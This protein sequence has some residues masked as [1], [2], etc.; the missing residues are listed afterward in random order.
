[1]FSNMNTI[2]ESTN[3]QTHGLSFVTPVHDTYPF[4]SG[5]DVRALHGKSVLITGASKGIGLT[6]A[7]NTVK[8][9]CSAIV[10]AARSSLE[11][12][13]QAV[14][15]AATKAG[16]ENVRIV[17]IQLDVTS[18]ESVQRAAEIAGAALGGKLDVL[19]NNAGHLSEFQSIGD[20]DPEE[21]WKTWQTNING[22]YL[23]T[24]YFLPMLLESDTKT[25]INITS[26]GSQV[27]VPG[28]SAYQASKFAVCRFTEFIVAEYAAKGLIA[29]AL[30]PGG[31]PTE[32]A[33]GMPDW[34]H[35]RLVDTAELPADTM[36]WLCRERREWL[37]GRFVSANWH[38]G[39]LERR[40]EEIVEKDLLKF[41]MT[42]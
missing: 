42:F 7:I 15:K 24:R 40:K 1:M 37:S 35:G 34:M 8:A 26:A 38:M 10:L 14:R 36:V 22:T 29:Y 33:L 6:T 9:G 17:T 20:S 11:A 18:I 27:V 2:P 16:R 30:H 39:E 23:C 32:L 3:W 12:A 19:I 4:I 41:R 5:Y 13:E 31:V 28:A 25:I 21:Y